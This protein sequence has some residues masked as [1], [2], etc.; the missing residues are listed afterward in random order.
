MFIC[1]ERMSF[2]KYWRCDVATLLLILYNRCIVQ[3]HKLIVASDSGMTCTYQCKTCS[4]CSEFLDLVTVL[5]TTALFTEW[6]SALI[7]CVPVFCSQEVTAEAYWHIS[8]STVFSLGTK[9][10]LAGQK[11]LTVIF[12]FKFAA[13]ILCPR[14]VTEPQYCVRELGRSHNTLSESLDGDAILCLRFVMEPLFCVRELCESIDTKCELCIAG[15]LHQSCL[16]AVVCCCLWRCNYCTQ[17]SK[18]TNQETPTADNMIYH[19]NTPMPKINM[20]W[21]ELWTMSSSFFCTRT[22][23]WFG[24]VLLKVLWMVCELNACDLWGTA[25]ILEL[26]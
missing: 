12:G 21:P 18:C 6:D 7:L 22:V 24:A 1:R 19:V 26:M 14:V 5:K 11:L 4:S 25:D 13:V 17:T 8:Q 16:G 23:S 10:Y 2:W 20:K 3:L 15:P 9:Q